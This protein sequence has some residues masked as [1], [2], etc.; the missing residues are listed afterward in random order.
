MP[1]REKIL[2]QQVLNALH[3]DVGAGDITS[4]ASIDKNL[5]GVGEI[6]A[7][8][9]GV[10]C[11]LP[12][13]E[14]TFLE[15]D[16]QIEFRM[17]IEDGLPFRVGDRVALV[18]GPQRSIL[19]AERTALNFLMH[20][21]GIAT[22]THKMIEAA[23]TDKVKILDTRKTT[24]GLR[25]IEKYAVAIGG[26]ENHR[27]GLYDMVLIKDNH[28]AAVGSVSKAIQRVRDF[29]DSEKFLKVFHTDPSGVGVEIEVETVDQLQEALDSGIKRILLDNKSSEHLAEMVR[30][31]HNH[32]N[33]SD[34]KL[35]ASGN[36]TLENVREIAQTGVDYIS[37]G[38]LTHSVPASDFSLKF[39]EDD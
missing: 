5:T 37:V 20:L 31:T 36:V 35:E 15:V 9:D 26:G 19:T 21:S 18:M 1:S 12:L 32:P 30:F 28:I 22:L 2:R 29:L 16:P 23:G 34:V 25:Y 6:I 14:Y 11:G 13:C 39:L 7:K 38:A 24:P 17:L 3:E 33:G 8:S 27:Y 4:L 10:V